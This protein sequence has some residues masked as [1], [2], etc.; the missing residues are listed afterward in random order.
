MVYQNTLFLALFHNPEYEIMNMR[1]LGVGSPGKRCHIYESKA[2]HDDLLP[3][4]N[5]Q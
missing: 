2:Y 3:A 4:V 5:E 1:E